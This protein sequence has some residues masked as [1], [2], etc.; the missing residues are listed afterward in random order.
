MKRLKSTAPEE[1]KKTVIQILGDGG[2]E[3]MK[4]VFSMLPMLILAI[5]LVNVF[6][7]TG[8]I[9]LLSSLL[10]PM[11]AVIGLPEA[12]VLPIVTK[13]IAG[14]TAFMGITID[15][16]NDGLISVNELNRMAGFATNPLDVAGIAIFAAAGKRISQVIRYAV[17]GGLFGMTLRGVLHL[18]I[19]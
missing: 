19:F 1:E 9:S 12:T 17:Y 8:V 15:L 5:F 4:I 16:M 14:G 18:L 13:F 6:E 3:G 7:A 10:A 2:Q 11:L